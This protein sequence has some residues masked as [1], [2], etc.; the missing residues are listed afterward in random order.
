M[1][2]WDDVIKVY[3]HKKLFHIQVHVPVLLLDHVQVHVH[4]SV[5]IFYGVHMM[6]YYI[7]SFAVS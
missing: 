3:V 6:R 4:W 5:M 7:A 2:N 1:D